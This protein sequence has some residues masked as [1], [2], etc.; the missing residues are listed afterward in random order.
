MT[1]ETLNT[2]FWKACKILRQ[3]DNT[4]SLLD[5][6][7]QISWLLFLKCLEELDHQRKAEAEFEG[8]TYQPILARE[9]Q[10]STWTDPV[11]RLTG[12]DLQAFLNDELFPYL[13]NLK[14]N[15]A[16]SVIRSLFA[17]EGWSHSAR[18][19]RRYPGDPV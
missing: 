8:K 9:F 6:V 19:H 12:R 15:S 17:A 7:E 3:D 10:W 16:K 14:G 4:N 5:Y 2:Q 1:R 18:C 11:R 13:R